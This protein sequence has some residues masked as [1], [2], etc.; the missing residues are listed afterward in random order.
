MPEP[1]DDVATSDRFLDLDVDR[2][3]AEQNPLGRGQI[4]DQRFRIGG[5]GHPGFGH[6]APEAREHAENDGKKH[7]P[8]VQLVAL[9]PGLARRDA[10]ECHV[11]GKSCGGHDDT[12][13]GLAVAYSARITSS[14][15]ASS[16]AISRMAA[17]RCA[18]STTSP[19]GVTSGAISSSVRYDAD[20]STR[21]PGSVSSRRSDSL[22]KVTRFALR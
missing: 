10:P 1:V 11:L 13:S 5:D 9:A 4:P 3:R 22:H 18:A 7:H 20:D 17:C 12:L 2:W 14:S 21:T 8:A 16:I 15:G 19:S 6:R